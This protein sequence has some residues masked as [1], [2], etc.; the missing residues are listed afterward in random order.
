MLVLGGQNAKSSVSQF[1]YRHAS[2]IHGAKCETRFDSRQTL[3][4]FFFLY[5][6]SMHPDYP[7]RTGGSSSGLKQRGCEADH[8]HL[9]KKLETRGAT[10][11]LS[12]TS[13]WLGISVNTR[14]NLPLPQKTQSG[15]QQHNLSW[16]TTHNFKFYV[17]LTFWQRSF[18]FKF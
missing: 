8:S 15:K 6:Q 17:T 13:T 7:T 2:K 10:P 18:T 11:Q 5:E 9:V 14:G 12:L 3:S 1:K 16:N 4:H